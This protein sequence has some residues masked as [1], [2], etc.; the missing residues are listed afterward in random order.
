MPP[1]VLRS[2]EAVGVLQCISHISAGDLD[3]LVET[4]EICFIPHMAVSTVL[5]VPAP[6][7]WGRAANR[8]RGL[9]KWA[10]QWVSVHQSWFNLH[11]SPVSRENLLYS[12]A[13]RQVFTAQ[14]CLS[15]SKEGRSAVVFCGSRHWTMAL[16]DPRLLLTAS[17]MESQEKRKIND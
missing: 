10:T 2:A 17:K 13:E 9:K 11:N 15:C 7:C 1:A 14:V 5:L 3:F 4:L 6:P 8:W 16:R 12:R